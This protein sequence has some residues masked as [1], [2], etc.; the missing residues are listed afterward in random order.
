MSPWYFFHRPSP[1]GFLILNGREGESREPRSGS[2]PSMNKGDH[3]YRTLLLEADGPINTGR[4][5]II[6]RVR[7]IGSQMETAVDPQP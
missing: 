7:L 1:T 2:L 6:H 4:P 5:E 3:T